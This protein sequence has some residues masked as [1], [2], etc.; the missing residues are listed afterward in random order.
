MCQVLELPHASCPKNDPLETKA[1]CWLFIPVILAT[2]EAE[3]RRIKVQSQPKQIVLK[4]LSP[5]YPSK[6]GLV[7]PWVQ[8]PVPQQQQKKKLGLVL[9]THACTPSYSG[10]RDKKDC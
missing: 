1:G 6:K 7:R 10:G 8:D 3:I 9:G 5:K 4:I 2:Q